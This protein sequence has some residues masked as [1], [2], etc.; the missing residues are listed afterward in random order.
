MRP[1]DSPVSCPGGYE[2]ADESSDLWAEFWASGPSVVGIDAE[3]THFTPPLLI[4][5]ASNTSNKV[6]LYAPTSDG[7]CADVAR[8]LGD[9]GVTK[10]FFGPPSREHL[11]A[12]IANAVDAQALEVDHANY[13]GPQRGLAAVAG[14][15]LRGKPFGKH[16]DLQRSFGFYKSRPHFGLSHSRHWLSPE[17]RAYAAAD[18]WATLA[19]YEK[20]VADGAEPT[21]ETAP[22]TP[23]HDDAGPKLVVPKPTKAAG[24]RALARARPPPP[25]ARDD[26]TAAADMID[27]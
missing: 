13:V 20:L 27:L 4:Q 16:K 3:G 18:A 15:V 12:K 2:Y 21:R 22:A 25:P 24:L 14:D 7:L 5:I 23:S 10:V 26:A 1:K 6:L 19:L 9:D 11:G 17:Q 8:L